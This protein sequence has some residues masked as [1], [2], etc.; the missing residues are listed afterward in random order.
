MGRYEVNKFMRW[1]NMDADALAAYRR[2]PAGVVSQWSAE[3]PSASPRPLPA[4][5][6]LAE[7][8][9][10]ALSA[11]DFGAL[12]AMGAHPYL[13]WSFSEAVWIHERPRT[14]IVETFR[15]AA[16]EVGHPDFST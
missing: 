9:V 14:W 6:P 8:E 13:L 5:G 10:A 15:E 3:S 16:A 7:D 4:G 2:D 1:V 12:Y 11:R